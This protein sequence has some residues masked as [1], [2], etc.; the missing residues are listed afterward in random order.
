MDEIS[1]NQAIFC[2]GE[3]C[4][5]YSM[6]FKKATIKYAQENSIHSAAKKFK[7]DRKRICEWV[8]KEEKQHPWKGKDSDLMVVG[9]NLRR[10]ARRRSS[11]LD[12]TTSFDYAT[13]F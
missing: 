9:G 8:R 2:K 3:R 13:C 7:F 4:Q 6:K 12:I 1:E 11:K 10:W 5:K